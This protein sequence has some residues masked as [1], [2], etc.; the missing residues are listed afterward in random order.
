MASDPCQRPA[1]VASATNPDVILR[2]AFVIAKAIG[3]IGSID[4]SVSSHEI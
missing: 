2:T 3:V 1:S 4:I